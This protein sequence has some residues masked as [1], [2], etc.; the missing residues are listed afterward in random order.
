[1]LLIKS[2]RIGWLRM[3]E[4]KNSSTISI[5]LLGAKAFE[6]ISC[7]LRFKFSYSQKRF[8]TV[9][10]SLFF[11]LLLSNPYGAA[12]EQQKPNK[13]QIH[14]RFIWLFFFCVQHLIHSTITISCCVGVFFS[15]AL[16]RS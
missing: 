6:S 13:T 12:F 5:V 8:I 14:T 2:L 1:M 15:F 16:V 7:I 11:S 10:A 3:D 4:E 9:C